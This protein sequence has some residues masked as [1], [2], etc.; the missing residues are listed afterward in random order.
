M[1]R[2]AIIGAG[3]IAEKVHAAYF[4]TK[5]NEF[6]LVAV[7]D[8]DINKAKEFCEK[9]EFNKAYD[10]V[11]DMLSNEKPEIICICT[12]NR[13]HFENVMKSIDSG[14]SVFCEK[15]PA[16]TS[17]EAK[18]MADLAKSKSV[19]LGYD[20]QHRYSE[21]TKMIKK[22]IHLLGEI[23]YVEANALRRSGV[24]GWGN[25]IDKKLQGG[26]PLIDYGIHMLDTAL[27]LLD[28]PDVVSVTGYSYQKI[29]NKKSYGAFGAWNPQ[30]FTV[31]D[32]FFG[33][34]EL[35]GGGI[36]KI[37]TSFALNIKQEKV[38]DIQL[39]G[40][41]AGA[42]LYPGEIYADDR[43]EPVT[44]KS[45]PGVANN[46]HFESIDNF[47]RKVKGDEKATIASGEQ[48]YIIQN[49]IEKLYKSA[50]IGGKI[51]L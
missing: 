22:N 6:D 26:G 32:S 30:K 24:P 29:G 40:D 33:I 16:M 48:G 51:K 1:L 2:V 44:L 12:P 39:C 42:N 5:K 28:F 17:Q 35:K 45:S 38:L 25:F 7:V 46:N 41:L 37:N 10:T 9:N 43:G 47:C 15:P 27:Y 31:E 11:D 13:F 14:A 4:R 49:I 20:F 8:K 23:Y 18:L 50:E 34:L 19:Y 36:L 21:E 3:Q